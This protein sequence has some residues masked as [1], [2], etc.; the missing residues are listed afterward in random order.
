MSDMFSSGALPKYE[1][2]LDV[3]SARHNVVG[4]NV[5][6]INTPG[7]KTKD[8]DFRTALA[9]AFTAAGEAGGFG[10]DAVSAALVENGLIDDLASEIR[11]SVAPDNPVYPELMNEIN[12]LRADIEHADD[13]F[14]DM[15][16]P[17]DVNED[18]GIDG[19]NDV[20][21][22]AEMNKI[23][24]TNILYQMM[25]KVATKRLRQID[26]AIRESI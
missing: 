22:D 5:A 2:A 1:K 26:M 4:H 3:L 11:S 16:V 9:S 12:E 21:L 6:N 24:E 20:E 15:L 8:I 23:S 14:G 19:I 7:Y 25:L 13:D 18:M 10:A 17:F